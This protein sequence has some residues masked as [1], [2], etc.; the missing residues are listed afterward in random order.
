MIKYLLIIFFSLFILNANT[1]DLTPLNKYLEKH[2]VKKDLTAAYYF[3]SRCV[4][5]YAYSQL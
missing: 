5:I 3:S 2:N 1:T 4:A